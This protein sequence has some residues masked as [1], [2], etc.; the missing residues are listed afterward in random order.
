MGVQFNILK[1]SERYRHSRGGSS[2]LKKRAYN[3]VSMY[4]NIFIQTIKTTNI[5]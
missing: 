1:C 4:L 3:M 5:F 2:T